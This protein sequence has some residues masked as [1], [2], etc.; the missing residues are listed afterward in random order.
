MSMF[1]VKIDGQCR[2]C[3]SHVGP[4]LVFC[5][6]CLVKGVDRY[7]WVGPSEEFTRNAFSYLVGN[8]LTSIDS[9]STFETA[10]MGN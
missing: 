2:N 9:P 3:G 1:T 8:E 7:Y 5:E 4:S 10:G 6:E